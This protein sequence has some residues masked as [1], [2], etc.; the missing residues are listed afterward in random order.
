MGWIVNGAERYTNESFYMDDGVLSA[1]DPA[2]LQT[3]FDFLINL[4]KCIGLKTNT[5]KT[6]TQVMICV[7]DKIR[8]SMSKEV[9]HDSR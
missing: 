6:K 1:R 7:L 9:Y 2:C 8:E 5:K 4:F 3:S